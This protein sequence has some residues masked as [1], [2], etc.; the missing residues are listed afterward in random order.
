MAQEGHLERM[1]DLDMCLW[2]RGRK[3]RSWEFHDRFSKTEIGIN[4]VQ[5]NKSKELYC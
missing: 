3:S 1:L 4:G 2:E 5:L